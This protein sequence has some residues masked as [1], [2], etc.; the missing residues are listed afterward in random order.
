M[1]N[2]RVNPT[3]DWLRG[4]L[5]KTGVDAEV[6]ILDNDAP[7]AIAGVNIRYKLNAAGDVVQTVEIITGEDL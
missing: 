5:G 6:I 4:I 1:G 7:V 2:E 3:A